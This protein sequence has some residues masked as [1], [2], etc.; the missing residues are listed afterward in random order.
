MQ[1]QFFRCIECNAFLRQGLGEWRGR[2]LQSCRRT[3]RKR[4]HRGRLQLQ[5]LGLHSCPSLGVAFRGIRGVR[6]RIE[7][8]ELC[9]GLCSDICEI[10]FRQFVQ[11]FGVRLI[12][13]AVFSRPG[14]LPHVKIVI[15]K[16]RRAFSRVNQQFA[17]TAERGI[18]AGLEHVFGNRSGRA[19]L[20]DLQRAKLRDQL[21]EKR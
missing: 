7:V 16:L 14:A 19:E 21:I 6:V 13:H 17:V 4:R 2:W 8:Q 15:L 18:E 3:R 12:V 11:K 10:R 20:K 5:Q 1:E 9:L